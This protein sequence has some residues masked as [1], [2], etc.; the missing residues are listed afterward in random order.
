MR[1]AV[2]QH[3]MRSHVRM[4]LAALVAAA[5]GAAEEGARVIACPCVT[6]LQ[7]SEHVAKAFSENLSEHVLDATVIAPC[8]SRV[9]GRTPDAFASPLGATVALI[10]DECIDP[11][12]RTRVLAEDPQAMVWQFEPES[13]LQSQALLEYALDVSRHDCGLI[14][15]T[16]TSGRVGVTDSAGGGAIVHAGEILAEA[17]EE[18]D[19]IFAEVD[20]PTEPPEPA[21]GREPSLSPI[22]VQR[23]NVHA[24]RKTP[25][26]YPAD[27]S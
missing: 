6:G 7:G 21:P 10:G 20:V 25:T 13:E 2:I 27:L 8:V 19:V 15:V 4:D 14:L 23:L 11:E 9:G 5:Q 26:D 24:G 1:I 16:S 18:T 3:E 22:L 12:V 17:V